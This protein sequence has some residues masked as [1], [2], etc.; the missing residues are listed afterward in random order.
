MSRAPESFAFH[1]IITSL[2][3]RILFFQN[4]TDKKDIRGCALFCIMEMNRENKEGEVI[5]R[6]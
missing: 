1:F 6:P 2:L 5:I 4:K 3:F